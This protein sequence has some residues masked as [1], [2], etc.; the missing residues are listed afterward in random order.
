MHLTQSIRSWISHGTANRKLCCHI[1]R[2]NNRMK[3]STLK[4]VCMIAYTNYPIDNRV[5]REAETLAEQHDYKVIVFVPKEEKTSKTYTLYG[6]EVREL[7]IVKYQGKSNRSYMMSY[8][9]FMISAFFACNGLLMRKSLD[10][11]HIHNMP[12]FII[13]SALVPFILGKKIILDIHDTM[14]E[15]YTAK[16]KEKSNMIF[17]NTLTYI[18]RLEELVCCAMAHKII[19][20]N[21]TQKEALVKRGIPEKKIVI[22]IN[23]PDPKIFNLSKQSA[24]TVKTNNSFKLIYHGTLVKRLGI[25]MT[26]RAVALLRS[27]IPGL[28]FHIIGG[29]DDM[30][31]F[32][33]LTREL[34]VKEHIHFKESV[35]LQKI[36]TIL[37]K[38]DLGVISNRNNIATELMLPV[39]MLEYISLGIP[40]VVPK[41]RTIQHYFSDE[42]VFYFEPDNVDSLSSAIL[43]AYNNE[44]MRKKKAK[45]AKIFLQTY[46]W[47]THKFELINLYNSLLNSEVKKQNIN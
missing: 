31:E 45:N 11:V 36:T 25:D 24:D 7:N 10:I 1:K 28:E 39:K 16:F 44:P 42:M 2:K 34:G 19:C 37:K 15:T 35:P 27:R 17:F 22:S 14:I 23:V 47:E 18:L 40:V 5:Q 20:V 29:G 12:N 38:M 3:K 6:V 30:K 4:N 21:H 8:L 43:H 33:D 26:I 46:G 9:K 41:L 32:I 13:F